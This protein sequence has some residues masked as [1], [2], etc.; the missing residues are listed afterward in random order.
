MKKL[1]SYQWSWGSFLLILGMLTSQLTAQELRVN[2][3][4]LARNITQTDPTIFQNLENAISEFFNNTKWTNDQF[5]DNERIEANFQLTLTEEISNSSF[6]FDIIVQSNRPVYN[7]EYKTPMVNIYERGVNLIYHNFQPME[8]SDNRFVDN[9]S[10]ILTFYAY[11]ILA[12]D[13]ESFSPQGGEEYFKMAQNTMMVIPQTVTQNDRGWN[14]SSG[15]RNR[16]WLIENIF[17]PRMRNVRTAMYD[18]H[19]NGL[20][21]MAEDADKGRAV[22]LTAMNT[23][24][25]ANTAYPNSYLLNTLIDSKS[26]E[27]L[28]IFKVADRTEKTSVYTALIRIDPSNANRY[29]VLR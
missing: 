19:R 18:Y 23:F 27:I 10:S 6:V 4:V 2:T 5:A 8:K 29:N 9:L 14:Q 7:S 22:I 11:I 24:N 20:D 13:Y 26:N 1:Y 12:F 28:E 15:P 25:T 21:I 17:N 16:F 3:R